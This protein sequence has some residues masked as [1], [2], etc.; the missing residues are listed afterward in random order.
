MTTNEDPAVPAAVAAGAATDNEL[1]AWLGPDLMNRL[2]AA[3]RGETQTRRAFGAWY[4]AVAGPLGIERDAAL[5]L[6]TGELAI[7][8][9]AA[10]MP[11]H[12]L[13][14]FIERFPKLQAAHTREQAR[15]EAAGNQPAGVSGLA[16]LAGSAGTTGKK[17]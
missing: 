4:A 8:D 5:E 7:D 6:F 14:G 11:E 12:Q 15:R 10:A 13:N 3:F 1:A 16:A 17:G 2:A 9:F